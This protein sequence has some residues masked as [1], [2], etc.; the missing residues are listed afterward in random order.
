MR[1]EIPGRM[2]G[3]RCHVVRINDHAHYRNV[4]NYILEHLNEGA[5]VWEPENF[6]AQP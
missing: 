5:W 1:N 2:W 6:R 4:V 3:Q